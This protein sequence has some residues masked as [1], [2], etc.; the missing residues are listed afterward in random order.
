MVSRLASVPQG[1]DTPPD[2]SVHGTDHSKYAYQ[3]LDKESLQIRLLTVYPATDP[4][5]VPVECSL[6]HA[7]LGQEPKPEYETISY[8]WGQSKECK[9]VMLDDCPLNVPVSA[10]RAIR[11]MRLQD[12]SRVLWI[13]AICINQDD[14]NEKNHQ[15]GIMAEIYSSASQGL[16][17]LEGEAEASTEKA[18][19]SINAACAEACAET[20]DFRDLY[21]KVRGDIGTTRLPD[22]LPFA[23]NFAA[24]TR[25]FRRPWF[26]RRWVIQEALLAPSSLCI[27]GDLESLRWSTA[28]SAFFQATRIVLAV[29]ELS[30]NKQAGRQISFS[31]IMNSCR[32]TKVEDKR[33]LVYALLGLWVKL[34]HQTKIHPL[35]RPDY[36]K[37]PDAVIRDAT[38]Y[39]AGGE[40]NLFYLRQLNHRHKPDPMDKTLPS[41]AFH[42]HRTF[43]PTCD[44][45]PFLGSFNAAGGRFSRKRSNPLSEVSNRILSFKGRVVER[46][47]AVTEVID[48]T[49]TPDRV[50][51]IIEQLDMAWSPLSQQD[52]E[53][54][55]FSRLGEVLIAASDHIWRPATEDFSNRR[56]KEWLK[57]LRCENRWPPAWSTV[58][59]CE[60]VTLRK[61]AEYNQAFWCACRNRVLFVT[62]SG[63]FGVGPQTLEEDDMVVILYGCDLPAILRRCPNSDLHE[64]IGVAYVDG[65]MF[66][67]AVEE[68]EARGIEDVTFHLQ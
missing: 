27:I 13:D 33:D 67:E 18:L 66:G 5:E 51:A 26:G 64:F 11:R 9:T 63:R 16:I 48:A 15:V 41:W 60:A 61:V 35:L 7:N 29:W 62:A 57:Y 19:E 59:E 43:D 12:Q 68:A 14:K 6:W 37:S 54:G 52:A 23:P 25:F 21:A 34:Q 55:S 46:V 10:E 32:G 2:R 30:E 3:P 58:D 31:I 65:I 20:N 56:H 39:V 50:V 44:P 45:D 38:R 40:S 17:W 28:V 49:D 4:S 53:L 24:L 1:R 42:W 8:T 36:N 22:P 47:K